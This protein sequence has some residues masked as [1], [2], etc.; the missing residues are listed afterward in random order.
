M[1]NSR[2]YIPPPLRSKCTTSGLKNKDSLNS[3]K[4]CSEQR[5]SLPSHDI[6]LSDK[7]LSF[8]ESNSSKRLDY[9]DDP[10]DTLAHLADGF[11]HL[12]LDD[13]PH[14][15][16][17]NIESQD[18]FDP[19]NSLYDSCE[20]NTSKVDKTNFY[21]FQHILEL[22][23]FPKEWG[24]SDVESVIC[25]FE[26]K[27]FVLKWVDDSHCLAVF[28]SISE[29]K[30]ALDVLPSFFVNARKMENASDLS[31]IKLAKSPG[32]WS[33]PYKRRPATDSRT[34]RRIISHHLG[35]TSIHI[36]PTAA[37]KEREIKAAMRLD[38]ERRAAEE[39][40]RKLLNHPYH[41]S[42]NIFMQ[43][44]V[45]IVESSSLNPTCIVLSFPP[46]PPVGLWKRNHFHHWYKVQFLGLLIYTLLPLFFLPACQLAAAK[47]QHHC[48]G[49][50][51]LAA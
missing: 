28:S 51:N 47:R 32:D 30:R 24:T 25:S 48:L 5:N 39:A 29:A 4:G 31:K 44:L 27:G 12:K 26:T 7:S 45:H 8:N 14:G 9:K 15:L 21:D 13:F 19:T 36:P 37:A 41:N 34:A 49:V 16:N 11:I 40:K 46:M 50:L 1:E 33:M 23:G 22:Y 3:I 18:S 38:I 43:N 42:A 20:S 6:I 35:L 17:D 10:N 2:V